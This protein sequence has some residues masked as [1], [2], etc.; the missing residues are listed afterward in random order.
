MG[1]NSE[2]TLRYNGE[3]RREPVNAEMSMTKL[4]LADESEVPVCDY[5]QPA[6]FDWRE[7]YD[8]RNHVLRILRRFGSAGPC[9]EA[10][11]SVGDDDA[12]QFEHGIVEN[13]DFFV[14]DDMWNEHD[15]LSLVESEPKHITAD[16]I[17]ALAEMARGFPGW[18]VVLKLGDCGLDVFGDK[19]L[20]GG[21]RFWDCNSVEDL[22]SRCSTPL[23]YGPATPFPETM[24]PVWLA[25]VTGDYRSGLAF[26]APPDRQWREA[27]L[28][29][30]GLLRRQ[31]PGKPLSSFAYDR[32]R[33]DLHPHTR[34]QFVRH[35]LRNISSYPRESVEEA[36][37]NILKDAGEALALSAIP[38]NHQSL[39]RSV[40]TAQI[41]VATWFKPNDVVF[42]WP[43]VLSAMGEP[44]ATLT[45]VLTSELRDLL[46]DSDS[47]IQLSAVF[48][49][50]L[51]RICDIAEVVDHALNVN[52]EWSKNQALCDWLR[53][54]KGG[55]TVYPSLDLADQ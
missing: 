6:Q 35:F 41:S 17:Q 9:G 45:P 40:S 10:D 29:L 16:V 51:L 46:E 39:A 43:Y 50:A 33:Y 36:R 24:Y 37:R 55:S 21:R 3:S 26:P 18:R 7:F 47:W 19:V 48:S 11:L 34:L 2:R 53:R 8:F 32:I 30:E 4:R 22:A 38:D 27:I 1:R 5:D 15:R 13:P 31:G 52:A 14:V 12:P 54:L 49:L 23:D 25:V 28:A 42:W 20:V 44:Q